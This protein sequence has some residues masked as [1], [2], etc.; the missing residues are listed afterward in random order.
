MDKEGIMLKRIA[1]V[2]MG[3]VLTASLFGGTAVSAATTSD[4]PQSPAPV[5][6]PAADTAD[7]GAY[8]FVHFVG[9]E[10]ANEE[11]VYFS[12]SEDG[13]T[14]KTLNQKQPVLKSNVGWKGIR[15]PFI[16][17][18]HDGTGYYIIATDLC[19][20]EMGKTHS[21]VW[22][23]CQEFGSKSLVVWESDDLLDWGTPRLV[24]VAVDNAGCAWAPEAIWDKEKEQ[25]MVY[26]ASR[27]HEPEDKYGDHWM[28]R[29]Y[30]SYTSD[31]VTFS[32]PEVYIEND[33]SRIDTTIVEE[34]GVYYRFTKNEGSNAKW[35][36]MEK[37]TSLSGGF[38]YVN[39]FT[40]NGRPYY[41]KPVSPAASDGRLEAYE[42]PTAYKLH[43]GSGWNLLLDEAVSYK[44]QPYH[45]A[46]L[47]SGKFESATSFTF[48]GLTFRHGSVLPITTEQYNALLEKWPLVQVE[49]DKTSGDLFYELDFEDETV[50]PKTGSVTGTP[51]GITYGEGSKT[52]T[53][54]AVFADNA[55]IEIDGSSFLA[56]KENL[57]ISMTV[58]LTALTPTSW[59]YFIAPNKN[60]MN[61]PPT[62]IGTLFK[63][64]RTLAS[65][66]F[67]NKRFDD[68]Y[69][70]DVVVAD[71]WMT[72]T[73]VYNKQSTRLFINGTL[74]KDRAV[75]E[76]TAH[77]SSI[78]G[79]TPTLFIGKATWGSG[80][81]S[82]MVLDDFRMYDYAMPDAEVKEKYDALNAN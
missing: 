45:T 33:D 23:Y 22:N 52:G 31:F 24:E 18:K 44:Y 11:Q 57:T 77:L 46:D 25:Y 81:Y 58:K 73:V 75:T 69:V 55:F 79:N 10:Q 49:E 15:D 70:N 62:Y 43:D 2:A 63:D 68:C 47:S 72:V 64:G 38:K 82:K 32:A 66:R 14:W 48:N 19:I 29:V 34:D 67:L 1:V 6:E 50:T 21:D 30:R 53:K 3:A 35:V 80:E 39:S 42:G 8:L 71:Q 9:S 41:D 36:Y 54:A 5:A 27:L 37:S 26:W 56:G 17:P 60:Q 28:Q 7:E 59:I 74:V 20:Y 13:S 12:V 16:M 61:D 76:T 51:T 4:L 78:L 65:E 40:I